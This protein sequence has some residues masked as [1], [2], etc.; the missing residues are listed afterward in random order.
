MSYLRPSNAGLYTIPALNVSELYIQGVPFQTFIDNIV[1]EDNLD[2]QEVAEIQAFLARLDITDLSGNL[3]IT[4]ANKNSVLLTAIQNL[5]TKTS[6]LDTTALTQSWVI[7]NDN[8]N[9]LLKTSIDNLQTKTNLLDTTALTQAWVITDNNRN[10]SL[11]TSLDSQAGDISALQTKTQYITSSS[12]TITINT[13]TINIGQFNALV[14]ST[15]TNLRGDIYTNQAYFKS[16]NTSSIYGWTDFITLINSTNLPAYVASA[17]ISSILDFMP[18]DVLRMNGSIS[19]SGDVQT[20]NDVRVQEFKMFNTSVIGVDILS[21][22]LAFM[23]KGNATITTGLGDIALQTFSGHAFMRNNNISTT[24]IDWAVTEQRDKCNIVSIQNND[25]LIHLGAASAGGDIEVINSCGGDIVF[26]NGTNGLKSGTTSVMKIKYNNNFLDQ[27]EMGLIDP[28]LNWA[29][30]NSKLF[31]S[32]LFNQTN[33]ITVGSPD[34]FPGTNHKFSH[35][36]STNANTGALILQDGYAG[37]TNKALYTTESGQKLFYSGTQIYPPLPQNVGGV[38]ITYLIQNPTTAN[39]PQTITMSETYVSQPSRSITLSSYN[40]NT[41]YL[42]ATVRG[43]IPVAGNPVISGVMQHEQWAT[44]TANQTGQIW[45]VVNFRATSSQNVVYDHPTEGN[46]TYNNVLRYIYPKTNT[47]EINTSS[48]VYTAF[49]PVCNNSAT[50]TLHSITITR[51]ALSGTGTNNVRLELVNAA[52]TTIHT[53]TDVAYTNGIAQTITFGGSLTT[54]NI[55]NTTAVRFKFTNLATNPTI[56]QTAI[57]GAQGVNGL[58]YIIHGSASQVYSTL[59]HDG[60]NNK[61]TLTNNSTANYILTLPIATMDITQLYEPNIELET[62]FIQ[63]SGTTTNHS[64]ALLFNDGFLSHL[65]S[66]FS[67]T[68]TVPTIQQVLTSGNNAG[69]LNITSL[70]TIEPS[71]ITGWNVKEISAGTNISRTISSGTY[72]IANTAPVQNAQA[73]TNIGVSIASNTATISN[74]APVQDAQ[75]GSGISISKSNG[76]ATISNTAVVQDTQAG[77]GISISKANN[78]ATISNSGVTEIIA[79]N[80]LTV[81]TGTGVVTISQS[82]FQSLGSINDQQILDV[83]LFQNRQKYYGVRWKEA[84][85]L[86]QLSYNDCYISI[87]GQVVVICNTLTNGSATTLTVSNDYGKTFNT[88]LMTSPSYVWNGICGSATGHIMYAL[89]SNPKKIAKSTNFGYDFT[90]MADPFNLDWTNS[91]PSFISCSS[92]GTFVMISDQRSGSNGKVYTTGD[93]GTNWNS[94]NIT[95]NPAMAGDSCMSSNGLIRY[96]IMI[97]VSGHLTQAGIYRTNNYGNAWEKRQSKANTADNNFRRIDCD[98]TGRVVVASRD[99]GTLTSIISRDYGQTWVSI[100]VNLLSCCITPNSSIVFGGGVS[101]KI[102]ISTDSGWN[103]KELDNAVGSNQHLEMACN[104]D[105]T[106]VVATSASTTV[107]PYFYLENTSFKDL[108]S[109]HYFS[110]TSNLL[111]AQNQTHHAFPIDFDLQNY[112]YFLTFDFEKIYYNKY[113]YIGFN[114]SDLTAH[115]YNSLYYHT[116]VS[117]VAETLKTAEYST[118]AGNVFQ[119]SDSGKLPIMFS[120]TDGS[121]FYCS[122]SIIYRFYA[123]SSKILI[124]ERMNPSSHYRTFN[125]AATPAEGKGVAGTLADNVGA[126][127][128]TIRARIEIQSA[129]VYLPDNDTSRWAP[130]SFAIYYDQNTNVNQASVKISNIERKAKN[131]TIN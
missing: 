34:V 66:T 30:N 96:I 87:T 22:F 78:V 114:G 83:S 95:S 36:N 17:V 21:K 19:K 72:T 128:R 121:F 81:S 125:N 115:N 94:Y 42:L 103:F 71:A 3:V 73:G 67:T 80:G 61:T 77:S 2:D 58:M 75:A 113:I 131:L 41:N 111:K 5:Q 76:V 29:T 52:G 116:V 48:P 119:A 26:K 31:V 85:G 98:A 7:T 45:D 6:F 63:P 24:A 23:L 82:I 69:N 50:L 4:D 68:T 38:G 91:V 93:G 130:T 107:R 37:T 100:G 60:V 123:P 97:E 122:T 15:Q 104:G 33:G 47:T 54:I 14:P 108:A 99:V 32:Q 1:F 8:R 92:D 117:S 84:T 57:T 46:T 110:Y 89:S 43:T 20:T 12:N 127:F 27:I 62:R 118:A 90:A 126:D 39:A 105:G 102:W 109:Q 74:T 13:D 79:G 25:I 28:A 88:A 112:E 9:A 55:S 64:V 101:G 124:I 59:L 44:Y 49:I 65:D 53:F 11:K 18:S 35:Y 16:L 86:S 51:V 106:M 70:G 56:I 120:P 40:N 129:K 10:A